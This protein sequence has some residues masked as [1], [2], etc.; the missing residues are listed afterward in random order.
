MVWREDRERISKDKQT[1]GKKKPEPLLPLATE[2]PH[3]LLQYPVQ[4][5]AIQKRNKQ[6]SREQMMLYSINVLIDPHSHHK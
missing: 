2:T 4:F 3:T 1:M 5:Q 6:G